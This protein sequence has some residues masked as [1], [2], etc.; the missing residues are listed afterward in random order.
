MYNRSN[1]RINYLKYIRRGSIQTKTSP[2]YFAYGRTALAFGLKTYAILPNKKILAPEYICEAALQPFRNNG[3]QIQYYK[4][5]DD[6]SPDWRSINEKIN[7]DTFAIL[8]VHYFGNPQKIED[9]KKKSEQNG[10][11]LIEDNSHGYGGMYSGKLLGTFGD[12][13]ISS[14]RKSFPVLNGG[15]LY[16]NSNQNIHTNS[17]PVEPANITI[18]TLRDITGRF[19]DNFAAIKKFLLHTVDKGVQWNSNVKN[20]GMDFASLDIIKKYDL[21]HIQKIRTEIYRTWEKWS[22]ANNLTPLYSQ[23]N[24]SLTPLAFPLIFITKTERDRWYAIFKKNNIAAYLWPDLPA[25]LLAT[26]NSGKSLSERTLCLPIHLSMNARSLEK[27]LSN[28]FLF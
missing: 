22:I 19:L 21:K 3:I 5:N 16:L 13:G 7:K 11:L 15:V 9:F 27:L 20:W 10:I 14:P 12:I 8:M 26:K 4:V 6:L 28:I 1:H 17:L 25:E 23:I 24:E 18:L 2:F